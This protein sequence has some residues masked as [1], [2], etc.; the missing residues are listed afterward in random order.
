MGKKV[1]SFIDGEIVF[2]EGETG[3]TAF[4]IKRGR[5]ALSKDTSRGPVEIDI[6]EKGAS[7]GEIGVMNGGKRTLTA[8]A[9]GDLTVELIGQKEYASYNGKKS[10]AA[11]KKQQMRTIRP[12]KVANANEAPEEPAKGWLARLFSLPFKD[13]PHIEVRIVPL[14]GSDGDRYAR[15]LFDMLAGRNGLNIKIVSAEGSFA[16]KVISKN[17]IAACH[18][19]G[20]ALL[21]KSGGD[22]LIWGDVADQNTLHLHFVSSA[23][24]DEDLPGS[25]CA[26]DMLPVPAQVTAEWGAFLYAAILSAVMPFNTGKANVISSNM[27]S[28]LEEGAP[29][30]QR[31]PRE[32]TP[33]DRAHLITCLGHILSIAGQRLEEAELLQLAGETYQRASESIPDGDQGL[34]RGIVL[35]NLGS[36]LALF[37]ERSNDTS[38]L[39]QAEEAVS[40]ALDLLPKRHMSREWAAAQNK[41]GQILYRQHM[42][43]PS[44]DLKLLTRAIAAFHAAVQ[45]YTRVDAPDRWA[46][47]MHNYARATQ[48]L[49]GQIHDLEIL[50]KAVNACRSALEV[51]R[52]DRTPFQWAGIQNT[53]GSALF[54]MGK[55]TNYV[56]HLESAMEAFSAA[57]EVYTAYNAGKMTRVIARNM[58]HVEA[59]LAEHQK[60]SYY[61][62]DT[63]DDIPSGE[64]DENWWRENVV[65][66]RELRLHG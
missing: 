41:L 65:D 47:I 54:L 36:A 23:P 58:E 25:I 44:S 53:L 17:V 34:L 19:E 38:Q 24:A 1:R 10:A 50:Q 12:E 46:D 5:V 32:F 48:I 66:E 43:D 21:R 20:R 55:I 9:V 28:A 31:P 30:A 64:I 13:T 4:L 60:T 29:I 14:M 49:G 61:R 16:Q 27:E 35:K 56:E 33:L 15:L 11:S 52:R 6:L 39:P 62:N 8:V 22:I 51:R 3:D 40:L 18:Q 59:L 37:G 57:H 42:A 26:F 45:V 63:V 7:F 2:R